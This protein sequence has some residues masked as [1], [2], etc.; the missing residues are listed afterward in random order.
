MSKESQVTK[1]TNF[2]PPAQWDWFVTFPLHANSPLKVV[3]GA[4]ELQVF[5]IQ[6]AIDTRVAFTWSLSTWTMT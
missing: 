6:M 5:D 3:F 4:H 2:F 1:L